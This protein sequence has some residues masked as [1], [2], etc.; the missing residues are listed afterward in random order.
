MK[1]FWICDYTANRSTT[2][3]GKWFLNEIKLVLLTL[4][5]IG[6]I[7]NNGRAFVAMSPNRPLLFFFSRWVMRNMC[8]HCWE[9]HAKNMKSYKWASDPHMLGLACR[10]NSVVLKGRNSYKT[11]KPQSSSISVAP[12][13]LVALGS[14]KPS[15]VPPAL[16]KALFRIVVYTTHQGRW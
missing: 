16:R 4:Q 5:I 8:Q 10:Q 6:I 9:T 13:L 15:S 2:P 14:T 1:L 11:Q 7:K 3:A 12:K